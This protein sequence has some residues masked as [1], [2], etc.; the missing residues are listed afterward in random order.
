MHAAVCRDRLE[1][2]TAAYVHQALGLPGHTQIL[3]VSN[4]CLGFLNALVMAA[5]MIESGQIERAL[6]VAGENGRPLLE[7]TL[8]AVGTATAYT[9]EH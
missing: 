9:A 1:P 3:D 2:A 4:A 7:R 5:G 8:R 6:I